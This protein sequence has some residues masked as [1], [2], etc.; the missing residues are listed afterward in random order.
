[1]LIINRF[2]IMK[3]LNVS[4]KVT[5]HLI[6]FIFLSKELGT[7]YIVQFKVNFL[8][9]DLFNFKPLQFSSLFY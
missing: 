3:F 5:I 2:F 4:P 1:M 9:K 7:K 6:R 8:F